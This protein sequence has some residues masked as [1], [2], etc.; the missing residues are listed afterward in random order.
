MIR[1]RLQQQFSGPMGTSG[2][3]VLV[4]QRGSGLGCG[5]GLHGVK[6]V[7]GA[8]QPFVRSLVNL[9]ALRWGREQEG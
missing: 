5:S 1:H 3:N 7:D 9:V 8:V 6:P 4:E 2:G